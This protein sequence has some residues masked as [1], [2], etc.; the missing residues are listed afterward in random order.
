MHIVKIDGEIKKYTIIGMTSG[1][2]QQFVT[3]VNMKIQFV[4][5]VNEEVNAK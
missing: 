5:L 3:I 1:F 4:E 2:K